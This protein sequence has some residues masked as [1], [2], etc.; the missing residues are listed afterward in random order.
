MA[1]L[2]SK[3]TL[4]STD[5]TSDRLALSE[6]MA[7]AVSKAVVQK[8]QVLSTTAAAIVTA[9]DYTKA[10][11]YVKNLDTSIVIALVKANGGDEFMSLAAGEWAFFPW[12]TS[13]DLMADAASGT[14]TLEVMIFE[15]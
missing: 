7:I 2:T 6:Q 4:T 5:L 11:V 14:P 13:V 12:S 15:V 3:I 1:T 8:R 9:A 10:F